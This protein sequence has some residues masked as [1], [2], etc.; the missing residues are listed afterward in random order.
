MLYQ[1]ISAGALQFG[2]HEGSSF[3]TIV[4]QL[5]RT[6]RSAGMDHEPGTG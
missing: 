1:N 2:L 5:V 3:E 6:V 4:H